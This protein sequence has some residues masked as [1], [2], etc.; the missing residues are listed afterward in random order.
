MGVSTDRFDYLKDT[1]REGDRAAEEF[2]EQKALY[3]KIRMFCTTC[4]TPDIVCKTSVCHFYSL[5]V[6][7][8]S[9][10]ESEYRHFGAYNKQ[11]FEMKGYESTRSE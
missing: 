9:E 3:K 1:M 2:K 7:A 11:K 10:A 5:K 6:K 8:I 4:N